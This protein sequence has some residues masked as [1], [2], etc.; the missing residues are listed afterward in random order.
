MRKT[1]SYLNGLR[2]DLQNVLDDLNILADDLQ[3]SCLDLSEIHPHDVKTND[4]IVKD[5]FDNLTEDYKTLGQKLK[6]FRTARDK[7]LEFF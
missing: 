4:E 1:A 7:Y 6:A 5:L 3:S 2:T